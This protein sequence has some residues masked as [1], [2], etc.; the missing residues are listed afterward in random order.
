MK[1]LICIPLNLQMVNVTLKLTWLTLK[2]VCMVDLAMP[3]CMNALISETVI[4]TDIKF[5][6]DIHV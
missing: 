4:A 3:V 2:S 1:L 6:I 5:G